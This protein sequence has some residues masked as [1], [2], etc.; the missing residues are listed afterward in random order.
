M[1]IV[2][3]CIVHVCICRALKEDIRTKRVADAYT[4]M[5]DILSSKP[6]THATPSRYPSPRPISPGQSPK[7]PAVEI[8][9][10]PSLARRPWL[11][12]FKAH[13]NVRRSGG[14]G[15]KSRT[16]PGKGRQ[17]AGARDTSK[18]GGRSSVAANPA[19]SD[20][21]DGKKLLSTTNT[22]SRPA[23]LELDL[24]KKVHF[25]NTRGK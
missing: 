8:A 2:S 10:R 6:I 5:N 24:P 21:D 1:L 23:S 17:N 25:A 3:S 15:V 20:M 18:G 9:D 4:L 19:A 7:K 22:P 13:K 12:K 16:S 14:I 11:S